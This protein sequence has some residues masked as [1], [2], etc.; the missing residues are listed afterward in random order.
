MSNIELRFSWIT[1]AISLATFWRSAYQYFDV[2]K[3]EQDLKEFE[4]YHKLIKEL[5][6]PD[7]D[8]EVLWVDRQTAII[9]EL[10]YFPRYYEFSYRTLLWLREK[11]NHNEQYPRLI[12]ELNLTLDFLN[13]HIKQ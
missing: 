2:R 10:R 5:V 9:Y 3:R 12:E 1:I 4:N 6:E 7:K 8:T 11:R 13:R